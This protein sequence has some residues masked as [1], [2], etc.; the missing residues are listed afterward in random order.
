VRCSSRC[1]NLQPDRCV[2][3]IAT[4]LGSA[5]TFIGAISGPVNNLI[6]AAVTKTK[7]SGGADGWF[8]DGKWTADIAKLDSGAVTL[9]LDALKDKLPGIVESLAG[10]VSKIVDAIKAAPPLKP[11][12]I[13]KL[14]QFSKV[15]G[16]ALAAMGSTFKNMGEMIKHFDMD[17]VSFN[18]LTGSKK[19]GRKLLNV[20]SLNRQLNNLDAM[21]FGDTTFSWTDWAGGAKGT[22]KKAKNKGIIPAMLGM[23]GKLAAIPLPKGTD[24][25]K[26]VTGVFKAM[27][28]IFGTVT[29]LMGSLGRVFG[30][31]PSDKGL[32]NSILLKAHMAATAESI[33]MLSDALGTGTE[34]LFTKLKGML[35]KIPDSMVA[36]GGDKKI[37]ILQ[38]M[39]GLFGPIVEMI[40]S[41]ALMFKPSDKPIPSG[42]KAKE[43]GDRAVRAGEFIE[44]S[45]DKLGTGLETLVEK[46]LGE[47]GI[48]NHDALATSSKRQSLIYKAKALK[49]VFGFI[50]SLIGVVG[51]IASINK[52]SGAAGGNSIKLKGH[53]NPLTLFSGAMVQLDAT[54][55]GKELKSIMEKLP[56]I[57]ALA[58]LVPLLKKGAAKNIASVGEIITA[59]AEV[60]PTLKCITALPWGVFIPVMMELYKIGA[61]YI[62][63]GNVLGKVKAVSNW[64][65]INSITEFIG[66]IT[67]SGLDASL[68][69]H[70]AEALAGRGELSA[71]GM[72]KALKDIA[73][74]AFNTQNISK[75]VG[76]INALVKTLALA[77]HSGL[78]TASLD[79]FGLSLT[80]F[81]NTL[82][83]PSLE[84]AKKK[85]SPLNNLITNMGRVQE[86]MT[87]TSSAAGFHEQALSI[88]SQELSNFNTI[89]AD[90]DFLLSNVQP[91]A[92]SNLIANMALADDAITT[93]VRVS[94]KTSAL[95][96]GGKLEVTHNMQ[97]ANITV[98]VN[99]SSRDLAH[100]VSKVKFSPHGK[101]H[102][103]THKITSAPALAK[104]SPAP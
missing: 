94:T 30:K 8:R 100:G 79:S 18:S 4:L 97:N 89:L 88:M 96:K 48:F 57:V 20:D 53:K 19:K 60:G 5:A 22:H 7:R 32:L 52:T 69:T 95:F 78:D 71:F 75:S 23:I 104:Q 83:D 66:T 46:L 49:D 81:S 74:A 31:A 14:E 82:K 90:P 77:S 29:T 41:I 42:T 56:A 17:L 93:G 38:N 92:L 6:N 103:A 47:K 58:N 87:T 12:D 2:T 64:K 91:D 40:G 50:I 68:I 44:V 24:N 76:Y 28:A 35:D 54:L 65:T 99:L 26:G 62:L 15:I 33:I 9:G 37:K 67:N 10:S 21:L 80:T 3:A 86:I 55:S 73:G 1:P 59:F 16:P 34:T 11:D 70:T 85:S 25:L 39:F 102:A 45:M 36:K 98:Q 72:I 84:L 51:E 13:V 101:G 43:I 61:V 63:L 27:G